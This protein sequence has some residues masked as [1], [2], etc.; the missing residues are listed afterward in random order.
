MLTPDLNSTV[1]LSAY[2]VIFWMSFGHLPLQSLWCSFSVFRW[3]PAALWSGSW[4]RYVYG[5]QPQSLSSSS[6][7]GE[8]RRSGHRSF[9]DCRLLWRA[10]SAVLQSSLN[11]VRWKCIGHH[12]GSGD[13]F[14]QL[15]QKIFLLLRI[16]FSALTVTSSGRFRWLFGWYSSSLRLGRLQPADAAPDDGF[17]AVVVPMNAAVKVLRI[18]RRQWSV[19]SNDCR[20]R[21]VFAGRALCTTRRRTSSS[22]TCMNSSFGIMASW[23]SST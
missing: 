17:A 8:S 1:N 5:H 7:A 23:S 18:R 9:S 16:W 12:N 15:F 3:S 19:Q 4:F 2:T 22:C 11:A 21:Y 20:S 6:G 14:L 10:P 13:V